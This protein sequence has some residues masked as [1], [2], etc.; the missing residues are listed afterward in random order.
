Y[1]PDERESR[2]LDKVYFRA[3]VIV[4]GEVVAATDSKE[5][6]IEF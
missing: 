6:V 5:V 1:P 2:Y 3:E 4:G